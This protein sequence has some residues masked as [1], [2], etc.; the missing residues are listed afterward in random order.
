M[1]TVGEVLKK[2]RQ[3]KQLSLE[4][5]GRQTRISLKYLKA[6]EANDFAALPPATFSKGFMQNYAKAVSIDPQTVLAIFRRD[7]DQD[8]RGR[9]VPRGITEP[10]TSP[11]NLI[12]PSTITI[13]ITAIISIIIAGFFIR[14]V[15]TFTSAP[16]LSLSSPEADTTYVSPLVVDG[17]T[18]PQA[19]LTVNN[20]PVLVSDDG[21]FST[22]LE[23][24]PGTHTI[25][26]TSTSRSGNA[27]T[28]QRTVTIS[29]QP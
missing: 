10:V 15:I 24:T 29:D 28:L 20:R 7:Y 8:E 12:T 25:I 6:I 23:L 2:A 13:V 21:T 22:Q 27:R 5:I 3:E 11:L 4:D 26:I 19:T 17:A 1:K 14:Q 18:H 16:S 9:I